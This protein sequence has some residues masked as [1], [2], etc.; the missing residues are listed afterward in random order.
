MKPGSVR[1]S[2]LEECKRSAQA[3]EPYLDDL[4]LI[5]G[6]VPLCYRKLYGGLNETQ[7]L[8][9]TDIDWAVRGRLPVKQSVGVDEL[10]LAAGFL[11]KFSQG[12][13]PPSSK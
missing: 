7:C 9:T 1:K 11:Q 5:G 4:V 12:D 8:A 2:V 3:L 13:V 6:L 10:L